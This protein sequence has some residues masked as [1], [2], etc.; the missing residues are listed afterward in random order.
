MANGHYREPSDEVLDQIGEIIAQGLRHA[1]KVDG[2]LAQSLAEAA[3]VL[4]DARRDDAGQ[5][6]D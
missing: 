5:A 3:Q 4:E 6:S 2:S 1:G